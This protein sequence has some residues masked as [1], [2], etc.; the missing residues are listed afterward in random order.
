VCACVGNQWSHYVVIVG[1]RSSV[2][3]LLHQR[4]DLYQ[5]TYLY[6]TEDREPISHQ[7]VMELKYD[8][9]DEVI[10]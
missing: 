8:W 4:L 2:R 9:N 7:D 6:L 1:L 10:L 5:S 3:S